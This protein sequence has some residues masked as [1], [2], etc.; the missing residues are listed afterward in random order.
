MVYGVWVHCQPTLGTALAQCLAALRGCM[1]FVAS[2]DHGMDVPDQAHI[3]RHW[4]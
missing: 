4:R 3:P 2:H 1:A